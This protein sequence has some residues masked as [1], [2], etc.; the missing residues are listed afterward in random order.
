[1]RHW[2][3]SYS[4]IAIWMFGWLAGRF[5]F[6]PS[7]FAAIILLAPA[8]VA[9]RMLVSKRE[10]KRRDYAYLGVVALLA[11]CGTTY[12]ISMWIETGLDRS[13]MFDREFHQ[14]EN[15]V[16]SIPVYA[17]VKVSYTHR[18]GG[19]VYL[20]GNVSNKNIHDAL[21]QNYEFM[22]RNNFGG[23]HDGVDYPGKPTE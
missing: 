5:G 12:V 15:Y 2:T 16:S 14:F 1:M 21:L 8:L 3:I 10:T 17:N 11:V 7:L 6:V 18:K 13:A 19:R 23:C 9:W 4:A 20:H 22:V